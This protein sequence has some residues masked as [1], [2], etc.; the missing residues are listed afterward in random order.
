MNNLFKVARV[1]GLKIVS[2]L[3][4]IQL[5]ASPFCVLRMLSLW[6]TLHLRVARVFL[7]MIPF[8]C[9]MPS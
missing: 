9:H 4:L 5:L 1:V 7:G 8:D 2:S 3:Y 6:S